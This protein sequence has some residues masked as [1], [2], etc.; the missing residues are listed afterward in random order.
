MKIFCNL[1]SGKIYFK[2]PESRKKISGIPE[3]D[4]FIHQTEL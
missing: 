2:I 3:Y 1:K 4:I